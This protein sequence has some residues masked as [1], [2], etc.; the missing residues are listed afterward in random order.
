M[1]HSSIA[2]RTRAAPFMPPGRGSQR[3]EEFASPCRHAHQNRVCGLPDVGRGWAQPTRTL[4]MLRLICFEPLETSK[5]TT[6][7][8]SSPH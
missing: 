1:W 6:C 4:S 5:G 8:T 3:G 2:S 7:A